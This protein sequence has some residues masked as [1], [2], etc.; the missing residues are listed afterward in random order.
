MTTIRQ[1]M[2]DARRRLQASSPSPAVDASSLLCHVLDCD[3]VHLIAWPEKELT[4]HQQAHFLA[5]L[6]QRISGRPVAYSMRGLLDGM[7][8]VKGR[9]EL[10]V[11]R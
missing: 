1:A 5:C 11:E 10:N 7:R 9:A 8:N 2:S 3:P 4:S 6:Q